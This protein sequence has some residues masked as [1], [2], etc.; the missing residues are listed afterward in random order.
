MSMGEVRI[1]LERNYK[2]HYNKVI[3]CNFYNKN[4]AIQY[5]QDVT[6]CET[7]IAEKIVNEILNK[8]AINSNI[9][10]VTCPYCHSNN[11]KK[12]SGLSKVG[13]VAI[14]GVFALGKTTKQWHCNDCKSDF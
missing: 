10:I 12:I 9:P 13:S 4:K 6:E 3:E 8:K 14:W 1:I 11:T 7:E 5:I 2:E